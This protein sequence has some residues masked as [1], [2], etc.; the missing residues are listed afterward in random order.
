M[1]E[2]THTGFSYRR[3]A[4]S[5]CFD[6]EVPTPIT[7]QFCD[8]LVNNF[9][10][11][12][13][14]SMTAASQILIA[15]CDLL[16]ERHK[17]ALCRIDPAAG[18][19]E[20]ITIVGDLHGQYKD[21]VAIFKQNGRPSSK[22]CY[23]FNGDLVDRG[24]QGV[25][26]CLTVFALMLA[27]PES[28]YINRGNHEAL[29]MNIKYAFD[30]E[31]FDKYESSIFELFQEIWCALPL[32]TVVQKRIFVVHGGL[33]HIATDL[34]EID[35]IPLGFQ[36]PAGDPDD[37][38]GQIFKDLLWND[39][40]DGLLGTAP[41]LRGR[42][43]HLF[44]ADVTQ[45]FLQRTELSLVIR[46][47]E[48]V[49]DGYATHHSQQVVTVFSASDYCGVTRNYGSVINF[50]NV[51]DLSKLEFLRYHAP[52]LSPGGSGSGNSSGTLKASIARLQ[53]DITGTIAD[54]IFLRLREL[55]SG[56]EAADLDF[57][58]VV[59]FKTW[60]NILN[61]CLQV[62]MP[63]L[64]LRRLLV[65][66]IAYD[67]PTVNSPE[68]FV[69]YE[70][71][72]NGFRFSASTPVID[73]WDLVVF[74]SFC[75]QMLAN[76]TADQLV[77]DLLGSTRDPV[78][79]SPEALVVLAARY[80][81]LLQQQEADTVHSVLTSRFMPALAAAQSVEPLSEYLERHE[82]RIRHRKEHEEFWTNQ[83]L[84]QIGAQLKQDYGSIRRAFRAIDTNNRGRITARRLE[85]YLMKMPLP[86]RLSKEQAIALV[87]YLDADHSAKITRAEF[88]RGFSTPDERKF[89]SRWAK[90][91]VADLA[92]VLVG[93]HNS[94]RQIFIDFD[95]DQ[96]GAIELEDFLQAIRAFN[97][98][99]K[100]PL[101]DD[102]L[103]QLFFA[104][105]SDG[106]GRIEWKEFLT[107]FSTK[108]KPEAPLS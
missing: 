79:L 3:E 57:A 60:K 83:A 1:S 12:R 38:R 92:R 94:L 81:S 85:K 32:A 90:R 56:F 91:T 93:N 67:D 99:L 76:N 39:P 78:L 100:E 82:L 25:E 97:S 73:A 62:N 74:D 105:D 65:P 22:H 9:I 72:L 71:F 108:R 58:G 36:P 86:T 45:A 44:G 102:Q 26:V 52:A 11:G 101:G 15:A 2:K 49:E 17:T 77:V 54:L 50:P 66:A 98:K 16:K 107:I 96:S 40:R 47:H 10:K 30:Q 63:W 43:T 24:S 46:S 29:A 37:R 51:N 89:E 64:S 28:V 104:L 33:P 13:V 6:V 18:E 103:V 88:E 20:R 42:G 41:S 14:L 27:L 106:S 19:F 75:M 34:E 95:R 35:S 4:S 69:R 53:K 55:R 23:V 8:L 61:R 48:M 68:G 5:N 7:R 80:G 21:L 59:T 87:N 70:L 84:L 31:V